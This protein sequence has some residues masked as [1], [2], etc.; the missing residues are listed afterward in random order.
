MNKGQVNVKLLIGLILGIAC[1]L[2]AVGVYMLLSGRTEIGSGL[3]FDSFISK[4][5]NG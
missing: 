5:R 3:F 2:I 1:L 4:I